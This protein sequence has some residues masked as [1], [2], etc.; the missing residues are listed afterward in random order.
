[1]KMNR[2]RLG[3]PILLSVCFNFVHQ[4][5]LSAH[6]FTLI[7]CDYRNHGLA[8][9]EK[10][11]LKPCESGLKIVVKC[12]QHSAALSAASLNPARHYRKSTE[13]NER[14]RYTVAMTLPQGISAK[15]CTPT[16]CEAPLPEANGLPLSQ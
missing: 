2:V 12:A 14:R 5:L 8:D 6:G 15:T 9:Q 11:H 4:C 3:S 1:M 10:K 7:I 16:C 13:R